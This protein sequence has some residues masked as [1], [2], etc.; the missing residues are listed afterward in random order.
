M[1]RAVISTAR[2]SWEVYFSRLF[3]ATVR[4]P[5]RLPPPRPARGFKNRAREHGVPFPHPGQRGHWRADPGCVPHGHQTPAD[6]QGR[7]GGQGAAACPALVQVTGGWVNAG[8]A[9]HWGTDWHR[10][11]LTDFP[12]PITEQLQCARQLCAKPFH[13]AH[14][15]ARETG[16]GRE[17]LVS[18]HTARSL[19]SEPTCLPDHAQPCPQSSLWWMTVW[20]TTEF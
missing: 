1:K 8:L 12:Q 18:G 19:S 2:D 13:P 9:G 14:F 4:V 10:H 3:P 20:S 7:P 17:V 16:S 15:R 11:L 6:G 5:A